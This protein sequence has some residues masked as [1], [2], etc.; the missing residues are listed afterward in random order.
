MKTLLIVSGLCAIVLLAACGGNTA[1]PAP[2][3]EP[4]A[5][6]AQQQPTV[7]PAPTA[8]ARPSATPSP[9]TST[10]L[11]KLT[12]APLA[13]SIPTLAAPAA[14]ARLI[15]PVADGLL[16]VSAD[17][18]HTQT[19][20]E[21]VPTLGRRLDEG[22]AP[23]GG[24]VAFVS[25]DSPTTPDREGSGPLMLNLLNVNDGSFKPIAP[26]FSPEVDQ[27]IRAA[28]N[29]FE[30]NAAVEAGIAVADMSNTLAWSPDGR[31]LAFIAAS[32][33][34]SSDVYSYDRE[35]GKINRL[36]D[37]PNQAARLFWSPD[38]RWVVHEEVE[39]F[40]TGAGYNVKAVWAAAPDGSGT[41]KLYDATSS[42]DEVFVT[43]VAPDTFL[44]YSWSASG[45]QNVRLI[46]LNT[47]TAQ[48]VG[49]VFPVQAFAFDP[50][51]QAQ[52][53]TVDD[54]TAKQNGLSG[55]LYLAT[56]ALDQP[57]LIAPGD[58]Y[59]VEWLPNAQ[60]FLAHGPQ[61]IISVAPDGTLK[62]YT[63]E[64][65]TILIDSPDG[66]WLLAR[67]DGNFSGPIG[68]RL[69]TRD[70]NLAR[71]I[72]S[73]SVSFATWSPDSSGVFY[74]ANGTLY[75]VATPNGEPAVAA[76]NM[77]SAEASSYGWVQP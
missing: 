76:A 9:S 21:A 34:P 33:G 3:R 48:R 39:S 68:L 13:T 11:P 71:E 36:T 67:G 50:Q 35:S 47:G 74:L 72:T 45:L 65:S 23:H 75:H 37:G 38:S 59:S 32:D 2:T 15:A 12:A 43:W 56:P 30:R 17:G 54:F 26:L 69:Y 61:G 19:I 62:N 22:L 14:T 40:G 1:P 44:V 70:G 60:L 29:T 53:Y 49:P 41:R 6:N 77:I 66:A 20:T 64:K 51:S 7:P 25:G 16:L 4:I 46:N 10:T 55:G 42:G 28:S 63:T 58:W 52:L 18:Q 57:Q 27:A 24:L 8:A 73:D 5:A 31:Y